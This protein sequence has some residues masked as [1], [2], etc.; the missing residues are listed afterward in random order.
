MR[1]ILYLLITALAF[2]LTLLS[3]HR[4]NDSAEAVISEIVDIQENAIGFMNNQTASE[5]NLETIINNC[6]QQLTQNP[7]VASAYLQDSVQI[8]IRYKSGATGVILLVEEEERGKLETKPYYKDAFNDFPKGDIGDT[9]ITNH[10]VL[11]WEAFGEEGYPIADDINAILTSCPEISFDM[12]KVTGT[13]CTVKSLCDLTQYGFVYIHTHGGCITKQGNSVCWILTTEKP[14]NASMEELVDGSKTI[15]TVAKIKYVLH[16]EIERLVNLIDGGTYWG[17]S[18]VFFSKYLSESFK[19]PSIVYVQACSSFANVS[20]ANCFVNE[21]KA[22][23]YFGF[24]KTVSKKFGREVGLEFVRNMLNKKLSAYCAYQELKIKEDPYR[25]EKAWLIHRLRENPTYFA[26]IGYVEC[27]A[28]GKRWEL[29]DVFYYPDPYLG[30]TYFSQLQLQGRDFHIVYRLS[31]KNEM[32]NGT[33]TPYVI[34]DIGADTLWENYYYSN[35]MHFLTGTYSA[36]NNSTFWRAPET[37]TRG[38]LGD[39]GQLKHQKQNGVNKL[40]FDFTGDDG[41]SY[42]GAFVGEIHQ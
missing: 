28:L 3:C 26:P 13:Q 17:V 40:T 39:A 15:V 41:Y 19:T 8:V 42:H 2:V 38:I 35:S 23:V 11:I 30:T 22:S 12:K 6:I 25:P 37:H 27:P 5:H 18:H 36:F 20:L 9:L 14:R 21:K 16:Q 31:K 24:N 34:N 10:K 33:Y 1:K 29:T 7:A 32:A 4:Q